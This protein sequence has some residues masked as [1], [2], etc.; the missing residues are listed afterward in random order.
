MRA[1]QSARG[2]KPAK[3]VAALKGPSHIDSAALLSPD[4]SSRAALSDHPAVSVY[5]EHQGTRSRVILE[6]PAGNLDRI[7]RMN[8]IPEP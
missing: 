6:A 5:G 3:K 8:R 4:T 7:Y 1:F 2:V